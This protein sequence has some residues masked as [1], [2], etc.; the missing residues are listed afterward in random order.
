MVA[1]YDPIHDTRGAAHD[2]PTRPPRQTDT[3]VLTDAAAEK[4]KSL[5]ETEGRDDLTLRVAVQ[6]GGCSGLRYQLFFDD[7]SLDGDVTTDFGGVGVVVDR[8][9]APVPRR[10][11]HRLRRHHREA[12]L[13][14]RQPQR[15]R[16]LRLRRLLP[17]TCPPSRQAV[18]PPGRPP[19][20]VPG[21][22]VG[23]RT[24]TPRRRSVT[25]GTPARSTERSVRIA[26]TG[27]I[28]TDHLMTFPGRFADSLVADK[29]DRVSL[30]FLVDELE[31][32]RG[33][34]RPTSP[35]AWPA[36]VFARPGRGGRAGLRRL[37]VLAGAA[38]GGHRLGARVGCAAHGSV[39]VHHRHR[40]EP[41]RLVLRRRH[42]RGARHRA[43]S[44]RGPGRRRWTSSWSEPTIRRR[45]CATPRSAATRGIAFAA[46]PSQQLARMDGDEIRPLIEGAAYLFTNEYEAALTEQRPAG[47]RPRSLSRVGCRVTT[48]G[49]KGARSSGRGS[50][51][52]W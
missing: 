43:G 45:C 39:R 26:V 48:L 29:L 49:P 35:S 31:V 21:A 41:D 14:D 30:S 51:R 5:L 10:R 38:R 18:G 44:D 36:W 47:R 11:G 22:I 7:R 16:F 23:A 40:A 42:E 1:G 46:D 20:A 9:S 32:R 6:P 28:A 13:H 2:A 17:L 19:D 52:S 34:W 24:S 27:S 4:V 8:M 25:R 15:H 37:P 50:P 33:G 12:G 3:I